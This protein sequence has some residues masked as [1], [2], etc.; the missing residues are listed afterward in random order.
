[1]T[2][3]VSYADAIRATRLAAKELF[4]DVLVEVEEIEREEYK[5]S[6]C[7]AI[8]LSIFR[9]DNP[10]LA[11]MVS[12]SSLPKQYKRFFVDLETGEVKGVRIRELSV[13]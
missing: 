4:G 3:M 1:M 5:G 10:L 8:T 12:R 9:N 6:D 13:A 11:Q 7:W 2:G